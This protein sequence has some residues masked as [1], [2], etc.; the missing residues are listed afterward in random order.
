MTMLKNFEELTEELSHAERREVMP[1]LI[2]GLKNRVGK[3]N[4]VSATEISEGV[5]AHLPVGVNYKLTGVRLRKI[6]GVIR[7]TGKLV[8]LCSSSKGYY[9][10]RTREELEDCIESLSQRISQ[11]ERIRDC[12]QWQLDNI[13]TFQKVESK[14]GSFGTLSIAEPNSKRRNGK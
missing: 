14:L 6:I 13:E 7:Y 8:G 5:N 11:Q 3:E 1:L 10:A 2:K 9:I 12:L 4:A